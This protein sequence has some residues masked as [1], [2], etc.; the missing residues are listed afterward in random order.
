MARRLIVK[1]SELNLKMMLEGGQCFRWKETNASEW[2]GVMRELLWIIR[3]F[4]NHLE[5]EVYANE[6][7]KSGGRAELSQYDGILESYLRLNDDVSKYYEDW[8]NRDPHFKKV[9]TAYTGIRI[10]NQHPVEN[11]FSFICSSNNNIKRISGMVE[12]LCELYGNK[13]IKLNGST[14][15]TFPDVA[16]LAEPSVEQQ[17]RN[18]GFGYRAK[19]IQQSANMINSLG[20]DEFIKNLQSSSYESAKQQLMK[21][22][23]I[24]AKVADCICLMSLGH[25]EAVPVDTHVFKIASDIYLPHLRTAKTVTNKVYDE[26]GDHFRRLYGP[27]AGWAHAIL[28]CADLKINNETKVETKSNNKNGKRKSSDSSKLN[29]DSERIEEGTIECRREELNL[30]ITLNSGQTYRW[31]ELG[32]DMWRGVYHGRVWTLR[33]YDDKIDFSCVRNR[34]E[35]PASKKGPNVDVDAAQLLRQY[36]RLDFP[37]LEHYKRW[38]HLDQHFNEISTNFYGLRMIKQDIVENL[39]AFICSSQNTIQRMR[40]MVE[41]LCE[42]YGDEIATVD[43]RLYYDFPSVDK[44]T[45]ENVEKDLR[46]ANFGYRAAYVRNSARY[47]VE[48]GAELWFNKLC[49]LPY[50]QAKLELMKLPGIGAKVADCICLTALDHLETIPVDTHVY[51]IATKYYLPH[52]ANNKKSRPNISAKVYEE[53]GDCF[54][55]KFGDYAGWA[56]TVLFCSDLRQH[57]DLRSDR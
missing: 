21:L 48:N 36:F 42:L 1:R 13:I 37:L 12:K 43:G 53:I 8:S 15:Y 11:I 9:A 52:L 32:E 3:Q 30:R 4:D 22:P 41:A 20:T 46:N 28:F 7:K 2:T 31:S 44:L 39:F 51:Q 56:H 49:Q 50:Q 38:S 27:L 33:Q 23:G 25:L 10:L 35:E 16:S 6:S 18:A 14:Y 29:S 55:N 19:Y 17:L 57:R 24:G 47:I 54:R 45:A 26:I 40:E 34:I 5:Y